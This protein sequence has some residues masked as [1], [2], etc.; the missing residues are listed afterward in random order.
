MKKLICFV[1]SVFL[2]FVL[3]GCGQEEI[4]TE[5][6]EYMIVADGTYWV[7]GGETKELEEIV[8]P[9]KYNGRK[10]TQIEEA[11]FEGFYNLERITIPD[12]V[13]IIGDMAFNRCG[14]LTGVRIPDSVISIGKGAFLNCYKLESV[15]ISDGVTTIGNDAFRNCDQLKSVEIPD[16][17]TTI[18]SGAFMNCNKI[19][20]VTIPDSVTSI[21]DNAFHFYARKPI[22]FLGT[23]K[24][25]EEVECGVNAFRAASVITCDDG[26]IVF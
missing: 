19:E 3:T 11:A 10:V 18:G 20:G 16:S 6:L 17:V 22:T 7:A 26:E 5:G 25:W 23:M 9:S 24:E 13:E 2:T 4:G 8:I 1:L 15:E 14:N 21:G 12:S